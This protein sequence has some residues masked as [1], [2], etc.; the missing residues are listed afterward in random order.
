MLA[1]VLGLAF[2]GLLVLGLRWVYGRSA[3]ILTSLCVAVL[4]VA[5]FFEVRWRMEQSAY[6][7]AARR[8][9][10][11][12]NVHVDCQRLFGT[13]IDAS[14]TEGHVNWTAD[15]SLPTHAHLT[16]STCHNLA[17]W[18]RGGHK[19]T[20]RNDQIVA[21]HVLAHEAMHVS[22][23]YD[24]ARAECYA[25]QRDSDMARLLGASKAQADALALR[26][27]QE[28]YPRMRSDY[29]SSDCA[30]GGSMDL[31]PDTPDW[32]TG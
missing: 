14:G 21:V 13:L 17:K 26:Y 1:I 25:I 29:R 23:V 6:T 22:G 24:E 5:G 7:S 18:R 3:P 28:D 27:W 31:H 16:W 2:A 4:V 19:A 20:A 8:L 30:P 9:L 11:R 12:T 32:P 15:G 10:D